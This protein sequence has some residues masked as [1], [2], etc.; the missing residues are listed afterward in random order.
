MINLGILAHV[1]AGKTTLTERFLHISGAIRQA[2]SVDTGDAHT[3]PMPVERER[4][5]SVRACSAR[6]TYKGV[7]VNLIDTPGHA[8]FSGEIERS[9][10]AL[11][12][13]VLVLSA[14]EGVQPQTE[15][16]WQALT[17]LEIPTVFFINKTDRVGADID[18]VASQIRQRLHVTPFIMDGIDIRSGKPTTELLETLAENDLSFMEKYLACDMPLKQFS[19]KEIEEALRAQYALRRLFPLVTGSALNNIR[20]VELMDLVV[21]IAKP[22][23]TDDTGALSALVYRVEHHPS[24]GRLAHVRLFGGRINIRDVITDAETGAQ[25]KAAQIK[26]YN[27]VKLIDADCLTAGDTG[28]ICG[29][30]G[31]GIGDVY[32]ER[33]R[34]PARYSIAQPLI[35]VRVYPPEEAQYPALLAATRELNAED[36]LLQMDWLQEQR[37]LLLSVTGLIQIEILQHIYKSRFNLAVTF[38]NPTVIYKES[39][40]VAGE[41]FE[42]YTMPKPCWAVIRFLIEPLP[43]GSGFEYVCK[44]GPDTVPYRY[45]SQIEQALPSALRQGPKGWEVTDLRITLIDGESHVY[46]THP[47]DFIVA[48]PMALMNGLVNTGTDL[49]EPYLSFELTVP[50]ALS[51]K[52]LGE[53]T[54][55]RGRFAETHIENGTFTVRGE[56]PLATGLDFPQRIAAMTSGRGILM[57]RFFRY[58]KC[59]SGFTATQAYRGVS[60]LDRAKYILHIRHAL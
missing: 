36:P 39:P 5:I 23:D 53:I 22:A 30:S 48:T 52:M 55:M 49:L 14:V 19:P 3:D 2:G 47:L 27:G 41:G 58:E 60:P 13:A 6:F 56:Y 31:C 17:A 9:L 4:G 42:A 28:V 43:A 35:A 16:I 21:H 20:I 33:E 51:A 10:C 11:D 12:N 54:L 15:M 59:P 1:D 29:L 34:I 18:V 32:G 8:D 24:W 46:H 26:K 37:E 25:G 57:A 38:G 50:E 7:T 40:S 45:Q 44:V